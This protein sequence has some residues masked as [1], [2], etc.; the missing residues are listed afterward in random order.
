[1]PK[2]II[3]KGLPGSGKS[4]WA[5]KLCDDPKN[6]FKRVNKDDLRNM[7]DNFFWN[8]RNENF[9]LDIR[10]MII[11]HSLLS[12][13]NVVVDDTNFHPKHENRI[14]EIVSHIIDHTSCS[15]TVEVKFFDTPLEECILRDSKRF[16]IEKAGEK[17]IRSMYNKYLKE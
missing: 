17:I 13:Y 9:V 12:N 2:I 15:V 8:N 6:N 3:C 14:R 5:R 4:T 7:L 1:M 11:K 10:D 16:G